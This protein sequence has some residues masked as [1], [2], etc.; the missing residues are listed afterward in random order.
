MATT[1][2]G[3]GYKPPPQ[4][5]LLVDDESDILASLKTLFKVGL[6]NVDVEIA[7]SGDEGLAILNKRSVDL[8]ISDYK[9]PGMNGL[10]FL[11]EARQ[12]AGAVPRILMTAFPDLSMAIQAVN[13]AHIEH[14]MTKPLEP[15]QTI[16]AVQRVLRDRKAKQQRSRAFARSLDQLRRKVEGAH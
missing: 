14:F 4:C 9:M 2:S 8:I 1:D 16:E 7:E 10:E 11:D 13:G 12:I 5:V 6:K 3:I 15:A